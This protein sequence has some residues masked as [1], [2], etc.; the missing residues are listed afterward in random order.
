MIRK[1]IILGSET[2]LHAKPASLLVKQA[3]KFK[4]DIRLFK[5]GKEYNGKSIM[6]ILSMGAGKGDKII[7]QAIGEDKEV[8]VAELVDLLV[9][10][11]GD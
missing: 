11:L 4:S 8:A 3:A 9:N 10:R 6:G 1:E 7:I 5:D 2:G